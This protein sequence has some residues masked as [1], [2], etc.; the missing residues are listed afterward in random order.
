MLIWIEIKI[1]KVLCFRE[2]NTT[3][4]P[5]RRRDKETNRQADK[6]TSRQRDKQTDRHTEEHSNI[7]DWMVNAASRFFYY[8]KKPIF[9]ECFKWLRQV[10]VKMEY[11]LASA[12]F[13]FF[14]FCFEFKGK[15]AEVRFG[16]KRVLEAFWS[17]W[18]LN[19]ISLENQLKLNIGRSQYY[20]MYFLFQT[21]RSCCQKNLRG[22]SK[23]TWHF[24][25][26]GGLAKVSLNIT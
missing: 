1:S 5:K 4:Q 22:H 2:R 24:R 14:V 11:K 21:D 25:G 15:T 23:N 17:F 8:L 9:Y 26:E 3:R 12:C 7:N 6:Q 13:D 20:V 10:Q 18:S 19:R 16:E